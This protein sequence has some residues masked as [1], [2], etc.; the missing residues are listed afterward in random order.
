MV[1]AELDPAIVPAAPTFNEQRPRRIDVLALREPGRRTAA[2][3]ATA[4]GLLGAVGRGAWN[5]VRTKPAAAGFDFGLMRLLAVEIKVTRADFRSDV[6]KPD[7]QAP[8]RAIAH[9]HAY[10]VPE[11]LVEVSE[12]P[13]GSGLIEIRQQLV[14]A[15][16]APP[17]GAVI[18]EARWARQA[19]YSPGGINDALLMALLFRAS[20][21]EGRLRGRTDPERSNDL[22]E[23][24]AHIR[25]Q[26]EEIERMKRHISKL[27]RA[28]GRP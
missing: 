24:H 5:D 19:P 11:G 10:A 26:A 9:Q 22:G 8:W 27:E 25:R 14:H 20:S 13:K 3:V 1:G 12:V 6:A 21:A 16:W 15:S 2:D 28:L 17:S 23:L 7:K 4:Q 18:T